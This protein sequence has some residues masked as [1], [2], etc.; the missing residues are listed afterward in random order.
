MCAQFI[1]EAELRNYHIGQQN[2]RAQGPASVTG[3]EA[4]SGSQKY[5]DTLE[6]SCQILQPYLSTLG[7]AP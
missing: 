2:C 5:L 4:L 3:V 1:A 6:I 7:N